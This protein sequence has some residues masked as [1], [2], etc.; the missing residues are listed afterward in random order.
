MNTQSPRHGRLAFWSCVLVFAG[1]VPIV[2]LVPETVHAQSGDLELPPTVMEPSAPAPSKPSV[3]APAASPAKTAEPD[4]ASLFSSSAPK[5]TIHTNPGGVDDPALQTPTRSVEDYERARMD[6]LHRLSIPSY[7]VNLTLAPKAFRDADLRSPGKGGFD[8]SR[9]TLFGVL[10][11]YDRTLFNHPGLLMIGL[12]A[13]VYT[14]ATNDPFSG[15]KF[16]IQSAA[17]HILYEA[18]LIPRQWVVPIVKF[19][20]EFVHY[21]YTFQ[22]H[23]ITGFKQLPRI[24]LGVLIFL[25]FLEPSSAAQ[26]S[27]NYGIKRTYLAGYYTLANDSQNKTDFD[28]S[29][30]TFR[31][32]LRFEQ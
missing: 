2:S 26:M 3:L 16:G 27:S 4:A 13:G 24:D 17:P 10:L 25:N 9:P 29:E 30:H 11:G 21:G 31:I 32:G 23:N 6:R 8:Q 18:A 19:D 5:D 20:Y 1:L 22:N 7:S 15:L 28:M 14:S 12:D